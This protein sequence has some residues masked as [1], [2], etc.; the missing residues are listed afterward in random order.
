MTVFDKLDKILFGFIVKQSLYLTDIKKNE[1][2]S[3]T[4]NVDTQYLILFKT[5][6]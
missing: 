4:L 5:V 3:K 6:E 2:Y 1:M